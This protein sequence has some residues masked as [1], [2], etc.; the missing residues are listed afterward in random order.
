MRLDF[1]CHLDKNHIQK[2]DYGDLAKSI[3]MILSLNNFDELIKSKPDELVSFL[4]SKS[5]NKI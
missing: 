5:N 3:G 1:L 4:T 2:D